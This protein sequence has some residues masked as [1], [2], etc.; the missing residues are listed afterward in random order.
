MFLS[1]VWHKDFGLLLLTPNLIL[2]QGYIIVP[3]ALCG[4]SQRGL[5]ES[6]IAFLLV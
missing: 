5:T 3:F 1:L 2:A 6:L 4:P